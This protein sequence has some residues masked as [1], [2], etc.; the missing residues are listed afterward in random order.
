MSVLFVALLSDNI[1]TLFCI[2]NMINRPTPST[3][4][5]IANKSLT[6]TDSQSRH[7]SHNMCTTGARLFD[8]LAITKLIAKKARLD[9]GRGLPGILQQNIHIPGVFTEHQQNIYQWPPSERNIIFPVKHLA[10]HQ[11]LPQVPVLQA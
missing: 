9:W 8:T 10:L 11:V 1:A 3:C 5:N 7:T 6:S 4:V 2:C